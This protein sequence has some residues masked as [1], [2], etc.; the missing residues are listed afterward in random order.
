MQLS[1]ARILVNVILIIHSRIDLQAHC[2]R[3]FFCQITSAFTHNSS[4]RVAQFPFY[5]YYDL[6][7]YFF[8]KEL[9]I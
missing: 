2:N 9:I 6:N 8:F 4:G 1:R 3:L 5:Q 7:Y